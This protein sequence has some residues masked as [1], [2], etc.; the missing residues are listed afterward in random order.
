LCLAVRF[1]EL[2]G[3]ILRVVSGVREGTEVQITLPLRASRDN[4][5]R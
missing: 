5:C 2:H 1:V 4:S 3:G